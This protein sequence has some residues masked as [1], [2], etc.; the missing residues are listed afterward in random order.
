MRY[1]GAVGFF[2]TFL[3]LASRSSA[4][5]MEL[6]SISCGNC[7]APLQVPADARFVTCNHCRSQLAVKHTDSVTYTEILEEL[8]ERTERMEEELAQ[9]RYQSDLH[10]IDRQWER[11]RESYLITDKHGIRREPSVF[12]AVIITIAGLLMGVVVLFTFEG[13]GSLFGFAFMLIGCGA[14]AY[15]Y[16]R[17]KD[18][19]A[20]KRRYRR[21]RLSLYRTTRGD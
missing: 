18:F 20:A 19:L 9:L 12:G 2:F 13:P 16:F 8:D 6:S 4:L 5:L 21:R 14:G 17:A 7:G 15:N 10:R 11:E 3:V 1:S